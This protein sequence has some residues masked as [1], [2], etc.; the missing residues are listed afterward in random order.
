MSF[1]RKQMADRWWSSRNVQKLKKDS[2]ENE[3]K[4]S[5]DDDVP[6]IK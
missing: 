2:L 5:L 1:D 3:S 6:V 4:F